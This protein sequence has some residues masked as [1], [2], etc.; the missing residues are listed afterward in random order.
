MYSIE[1]PR[2]RLI[3]ATLALVRA[4]VANHHELGRRLQA[5]VPEN[6]PPETMRDALPMFLAAL[7]AAPDRV[8]WCQWYG[9][10]TAEEGERA[11]LVGSAG[12][13]GP[14]AA[15]T[16]EI[17]YA[18]LPQ[19]HGKGYATEMV[20]SLVGWA[21]RHAEVNQIVAETDG[22]NPA[23]VRVLEK[24]GFVGTGAASVPEGWR[25]VYRRGV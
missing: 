21:L 14:P 12:F 15:G 6:W 16:V 10:S 1:T 24:A 17:G 20:R 18:V 9:V 2:M 23:S 3:P 19:Y 4:E 5:R 25:F 11:V 8:G 7:E 22:A 13:K